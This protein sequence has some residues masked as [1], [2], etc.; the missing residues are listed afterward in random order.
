MRREND[1]MDT[2]RFGAAQERA[3]VLRIFERV[4]DEDE[5]WLGALD[6]TGQ[7]LVE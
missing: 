1:A 7:D 5:R 6:G 2:G 3:D 4:E